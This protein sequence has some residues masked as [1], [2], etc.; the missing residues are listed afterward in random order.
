[1]PALLL[2]YLLAPPSVVGAV[3]LASGAFVVL[4]VLRTVRLLRRQELANRRF[5]SL[6][7]NASDLVTLVGSDMTIRFVSPSAE[8]LLGLTPDQ[9]EG[10]SFAALIQ[11]DQAARA[12]EFILGEKADS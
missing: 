8:R 6:V 4:V 5:E 9:L 1:M 12:L 7:R 10:S 11:P 2:A 3:A